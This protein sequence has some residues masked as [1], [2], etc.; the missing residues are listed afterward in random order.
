MSSLPVFI[1]LTLS[2]SHACFNV[3][4]LV[5][6][7]CN[8]WL[9]NRNDLTGSTRCQCRRTLYRSLARLRSHTD[10]L[11]T[12]PISYFLRQSFVCLCRPLMESMSTDSRVQVPYTSLFSASFDYLNLRGNLRT[13]LIRHGFSS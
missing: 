3:F 1:S 7:C 4:L 6:I 10:C 5:S 12:F 8:K 11:Y 9:L 2:L 13:C